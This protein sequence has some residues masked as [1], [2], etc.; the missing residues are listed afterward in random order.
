MTDSTAVRRRM[1]VVIE[2]G[3][4]HAAHAKNL[5]AALGASERATVEF[6]LLG[7]HDDVR[8]IDTLPLMS[9]WT[10][11]A[12]KAANRAV[13]AWLRDG[14]VDG[15]FLHTQVVSVGMGRHMRRIPSIVSL[16]ATPSQ[17]DE[18]G[19][20]YAH[21][22]GPA[23][24]EKLKHQATKRALERAASLVA[25]SEWTADGIVRDFGI[26]RDRID[27]LAPGVMTDVWG[28]TGDRHDDGVVR[29]LFVG[30]DLPRKGGDL[31][32]EAIRRL[33]TD[34][35][36]ASAGVEVE[37]HLAT[38]AEL[39]DEP[40][41]VV[42]NGLT[43]NSPELIA[44][45]HRCDLFA[46]PT[47]GD[48]LPM[49]LGEAALSELPLISTDVGAIAE[50]VRTGETGTVVDVEVAAIEAAIKPYVLDRD[51]RR[52][53]G[54]AARRFAETN[55]DA[56]ANAEK[57]LDRML[58][59]AERRTP[60]KVVLSV[61][62]EVAPDIRRQID[63]GERPLAD[64]V[65]IADRLGAEIVDRPRVAADGGPI[66]SL[67]GRIHPDIAMGY[68]LFRRRRDAD[69]IITDGEQVGYP[70][71]LLMNLGGRRQTAHLM[72]GH[73]LT[74]SK[75]VLLAKA[76]RLDRSIDEYL[77]Y[78]TA[79]IDA[80]VE[81][82]I[83]PADKCTLIDFMVDTAF[84]APG[85][86]RPER[87]RPLL[88]TAGR[89]SRDYPTFIAA[90]EGLDLDVLIASASPWSKRADNA[91]DVDIPDNVEV[92]RLTQAELRDALEASAFCVVP[93][94]ETDFQA[95]ITTILEA[96]AVGRAT[97]CTKTTGQTDVIDDGVTGRYVAPG[98][99]ADLRAVIEELI[100]D[101]AE[102]DR[103]GAAARQVAIERMD[104]RV[105]A[106]V[107][108]TAV[109]RHRGRW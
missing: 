98:D 55:L 22:P 48:C 39:P 12:G 14:P 63:A 3:L 9:N 34:P 85:A 99:A 66:T 106:E 37:V 58:E 4:G 93:V 89:E 100:A 44:L 11:R 2:N 79:Q 80:T 49:V 102:A 24:I 94:V 23:P 57:V 19:E 47:K 21:D 29:V 107:F 87:E 67:L 15:L 73:R 103:L 43:P 52:R 105:Y 46:L 13:D 28:R 50:V 62:G 38:G 83:A 7:F 16:D 68:D 32:M 82:G 108:A 41:I 53:T 92:T 5:Q 69:V 17:I 25:W 71:A 88:V 35:E 31:L 104:V 76:A 36:L 86:G 109:E 51:L 72:I 90:I 27:V 33:R 42:H 96:M 59:H 26:P 77:L 70:L 45:Y 84:F 20:F 97:V 75:K 10:V 101:P 18:L 6:A 54:E 40:G 61:S 95:G 30:G 60:P 91:H 56:R 64:Y 78:A 74:A 1:G 65:A 81:R 8:R